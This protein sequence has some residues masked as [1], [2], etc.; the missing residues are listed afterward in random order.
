[1]SWFKNI[2]GSADTAADVVKKATD[3]IYNGID[4]AIYTDEEKSDAYQK[5]QETLLEITKVAYDNNSTRN[6]TRRWLAWLI[7]GWVLLNA[8]IA[9]VFAALGMDTIV[10]KIIDIAEGF[11]IGWAFV[12]VISFFF[13]VQLPR[14]WKK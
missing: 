4:K 13:V 1:M 9:I 10:Q 11:Q 5:G 2:F 14:A 7:T 12:G 3:G 8:Q 6:V